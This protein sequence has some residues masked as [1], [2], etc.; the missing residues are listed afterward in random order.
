MVF[1]VSAG[2]FLS[3]P[4]D[5]R[6]GIEFL[7]TTAVSVAGLMLVAKR[8]I[9]W[10]AGAL[11]LVLFAAHLFFTDPEARLRFAFIYFGIALGLAAMDWNRVRLLFRERAAGAGLG[12][13][14]GR[15]RVY[16]PSPSPRP[17]PV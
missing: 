14:L 11:L 8:V 13:P 6:Q 16:M 4:L 9:S 17:C 7:L 1:S 15:I 5:D 3:F 10:N 2:E 12:Q